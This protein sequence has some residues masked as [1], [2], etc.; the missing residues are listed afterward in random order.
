MVHDSDVSSNS[1][2]AYSIKDFAKLHTIAPKARANS[3][4]Y[5]IFEMLHNEA[6]VRNPSDFSNE[7]RVDDFTTQ[8]S[9][10]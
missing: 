6:L 7:T 9:V 2:H 1:L 3:F 5:Q 4:F 8:I 10:N